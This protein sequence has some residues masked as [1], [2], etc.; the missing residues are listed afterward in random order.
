MS[1][2]TETNR[3]ITNRRHSLHHPRLLSFLP[4]LSHFIPYQL[5]KASEREGKKAQRFNEECRLSISKLKEADNWEER[6]TM[7]IC[8]AVKNNSL[9]FIEK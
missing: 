8:H 9:F 2:K 1:V 4:P 7:F 5:T 3:V 6:Q